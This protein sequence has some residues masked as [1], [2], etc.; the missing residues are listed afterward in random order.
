MSQVIKTQEIRKPLEK[1]ITEKQ[2]YKLAISLRNEIFILIK[3]SVLNTYPTL[4]LR[5]LKLLI[6]KITY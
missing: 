4:F 6:Y 2:K 1:Y 3:P 5:Y